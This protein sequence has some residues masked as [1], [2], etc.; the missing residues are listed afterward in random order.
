MNSGVT[1]FCAWLKKAHL[2]YAVV[3]GPAP[4]RPQTE[5][6]VTADIES[7]TD[8]N[9]VCKSQRA[10]AVIVIVGVM[11]HESCA[12]AEDTVMKPS[13]RRGPCATYWFVAGS[14]AIWPE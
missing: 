3:A 7:L 1:P 6:N 5:A 13:R 9:G 11:R 2:L 14:S 12:N 8:W 4:E 10:P